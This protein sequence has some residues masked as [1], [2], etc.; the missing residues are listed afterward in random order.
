MGV[1]LRGLDIGMHQQFL[2]GADVRAAFECGKVAALDSPSSDVR[3][4]ASYALRFI[5]VFEELEHLGHACR[6]GLGDS[7]ERVRASCL[8]LLAKFRLESEE[9]VLSRVRSDPSAIVRDEEIGI[10]IWIQQRA[11]QRYGT[12][13]RVAPSVLRKGFR[14][15][16]APRRHRV[17]FDVAGKTPHR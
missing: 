11:E 13:C 15:S 10:K 14:F 16:L 2:D 1:D 4:S 7:D 6:S 8:I 5:K 12:R 9:F 3:W 17:H